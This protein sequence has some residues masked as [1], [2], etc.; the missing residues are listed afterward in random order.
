MHYTK[1]HYPWQLQTWLV[2][3]TQ[4]LFITPLIYQVNNYLYIYFIIHTWLYTLISPHINSV[5]STVPDN[6]SHNRISQQMNAAL[7]SFHAQ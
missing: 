2:R 3:I 7:H 4:I 1:I 6:S 5:A